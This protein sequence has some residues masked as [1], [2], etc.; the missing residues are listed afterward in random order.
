MIIASL[1]RSGPAQSLHSKNKL[2][3]LH[4]PGQLNLTAIDSDGALSHER[5]QLWSS[6]ALQWLHPIFQILNHFMH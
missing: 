5:P 4:I 6:R 3:S 1:E 2:L